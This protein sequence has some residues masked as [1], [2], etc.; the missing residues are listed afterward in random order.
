MTSVGIMASSV[1][2]SA[3]T[4]VLMEPFNNFTTNSWTLAGTAPTIV[5]GRTGTCCQ[6]L[7]SN[8]ASYNIAAPQQSDTL[9]FGCAFRW[10]D[11]TTPTRDIVQFR[12]FSVTPGAALQTRLRVDSTGALL[13]VDGSGG[14]LGSPSSAGVV[15]R[16]VWAYIEAQTKLADAPNGTTTVRLNGV[17]V[18]T[19]TGVDTRPNAASSVYDQI[20]LTPGVGGTTEQWDDLYLT[21][22]AGAPF[23]GDITIP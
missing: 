21:M 15:A 13:V 5:A 3:G 1:V 17:T 2:T 19:V 10:T 7:A 8:S 22:G 20:R 11:A 18:I 4:D 23:K 16:N 6:V 12:G 14:T 9:T